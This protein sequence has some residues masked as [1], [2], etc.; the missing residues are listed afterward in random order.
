MIVG[1]DT[2]FKNLEKKVGVFVLVAVMGIIGVV[3]FIIKENDL[4]KSTYSVSL[5]A[6]KGTGFSQGMPIKLSGFRIGRVKSITLND[7]AAVDVV[8]QIDLK[9]KKWIRKD[10]VAR[11]IKEGMIGDYI[12]EINSGSSTELI[13]ENGVITLDKTKAM[14]EIVEEIAD[15]VKPVL[16]DIRDIIAYV[17]SENG[18]VKQTLRNLNAFTGNIEESREKTDRLL[19][20]GN[21]AVVAVGKRFDILLTKAE[22][23]IDQAGP[24]LGKVDN[25]LLQ[26]ETKLPQMLEKIDLTLNHLEAVSRDLK[27]TSSEA[28]PQIPGLIRK[29]EGVIDQGEG[30]LEGAKWLWPLS[31]VMTPADDKSLLRRDSNE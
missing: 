31:S 8:L 25:S 26:V 11:L 19:V 4:F 7:S 22:E 24:I 16:M 29:T 5:T 18:D 20:S 28:L 21:N 13:P 12:I 27:S 10:S 15:K 2:R 6:P 14:D 1:T 23:R 30:L 3:L 9:Y 17:N